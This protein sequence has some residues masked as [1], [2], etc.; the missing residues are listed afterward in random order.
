MSAPGRQRGITLLELLIALV[1]LGFIMTLLFAGLDLGTRS[2]DAG[3]RR[4]NGASRQAVVDDFLRRTLEGAWPLMWRK[5]DEDVLAFAGEAESLRFAG[6]LAR[7]AGTAAKQLLAIELA[8]G[9]Q[10]RDLV[11]RWQWPDPRAPGFGPLDSAPPKVIVKQVKAVRFAYF[12][13][14]SAS[15]EPAW[16]D[17]WLARKV[18][19]DLI[20]LR[21]EPHDDAPWPDIVVAPRQRPAS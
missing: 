20:R 1:L 9:G 15:D 17:R 2:W 19:P 11:V 14:E 8:P 6:P 10:G 16:H 3:E 4:M 7:S 12:G 5:D 21:I 18:L 13:A